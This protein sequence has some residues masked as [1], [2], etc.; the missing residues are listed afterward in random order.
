VSS[1]FCLLTETWVMFTFWNI[2]AQLSWWDV[3]SFHEVTHPFLNIYPMFRIKAFQGSQV[4]LNQ[5]Q[6][7]MACDT[8][9]NLTW[10]DLSSRPST[11]ALRPWLLWSLVHGM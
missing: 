1:T 4:L 7:P 11:P 8:L 10:G 9:E 6:V 3:I 2:R 5:M